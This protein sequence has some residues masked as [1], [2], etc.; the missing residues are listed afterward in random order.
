M[1]NALTKA[2]PSI[3]WRFAWSAIIYF[4][5][6]F[7]FQTDSIYQKLT[8]TEGCSLPLVLCLYRIERNLKRR[9]PQFELENA[10]KLPVRGR[11]SSQ[12]LRLRQMDILGWICF[13]GIVVCLVAPWASLP[14]VLPHHRGD[15]LS[16]ATISMSMTGLLCIVILYYVEKY[17]K[18]PMFPSHVSRTQPFAR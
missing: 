14:L 17:S 18:Y 16:A 1:K 12:L 8:A 11:L 2:C 5:M 10:T 6:C 9:L 3:Q 15:G 13:M 4:G 7:T